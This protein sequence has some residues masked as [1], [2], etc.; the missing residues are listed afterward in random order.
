MKN[1]LQAEH[2]RADRRLLWLKKLYLELYHDGESGNVTGAGAQCPSTGGDS[3]TIVCGGLDSPDWSNVSSLI[4]GPKPME[5]LQ[6][7]NSRFLNK[8]VVTSFNN[9]YVLLSILAQK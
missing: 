4:H 1:L 2:G 7:G 5:A 3:Q 9:A 6:V 8:V